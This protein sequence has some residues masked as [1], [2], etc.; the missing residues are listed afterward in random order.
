[1]NAFHQKLEAFFCS[2][3][4]TEHFNCIFTVYK[5][6]LWESHSKP[7]RQPIIQRFN[8][9]FLHHKGVVNYLHTAVK[10]VTWIQYMSRPRWS[11]LAAENTQKTTEINLTTLFY[12]KAKKKKKKKY[13]KSQIKWSIY[14]IQTFTKTWSAKVSLHLQYLSAFILLLL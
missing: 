9:Q 8:K 2:C 12:S 1:M 14:K 13:S 11:Q 4:P 6:K 10:W 5:H 3:L 7:L